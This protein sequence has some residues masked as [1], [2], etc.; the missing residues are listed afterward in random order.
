M[1]HNPDTIIHWLQQRLKFK[2]RDTVASSQL[3]AIRSD[4]RFFPKSI[5]VDLVNKLCHKYYPDFDIDRISD[6]NIGYTEKERMQIK[7]L[8]MDIIE[9]TSTYNAPDSQQELGI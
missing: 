2:H 4:Y 9:Y 1:I 6:M 5:P 8:I 3:D 7:N